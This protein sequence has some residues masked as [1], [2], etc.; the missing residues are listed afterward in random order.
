MKV[1]FNIEKKENGYSIET[2]CVDIP[3]FDNGDTNV[4]EYKKVWD[5]ISK[6]VSSMV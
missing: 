5:I 2:E 3:K 1:L 4:E 6:V